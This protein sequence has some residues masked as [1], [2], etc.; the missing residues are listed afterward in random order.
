M[1]IK[2][3]VIPPYSCKNGHNFKNIKI[4]DVGVYV[5][6]KEHFILLVGMKTSITTMENS[7][8]IP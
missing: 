1:Q 6:K 8:E 4:I 3:S 5:V 2:T 7:V